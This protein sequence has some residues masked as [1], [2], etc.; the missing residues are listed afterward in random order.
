MLGQQV[1]AQQIRVVRR[2]IDR[3]RQTPVELHPLADIRGTQL[4]Q[5]DPSRQVR[6]STR[7]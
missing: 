4:D 1:Q 3:V 6:P 7:T 2:D 5:R